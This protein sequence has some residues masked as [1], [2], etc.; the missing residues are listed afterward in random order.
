MIASHTRRFSAGAHLPFHVEIAL[1][2]YETPKHSV[3]RKIWEGGPHEEL[4]KD[5]EYHAPRPRL[6]QDVSSQ[7]T[8]ELSMLSTLSIHFNLPISIDLQV[9]ALGLR[10]EDG[11]ADLIATHLAFKC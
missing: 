5:M 8:T 9:A 3:R 4:K 2:R 10:P 6:T 1:A 7:S 11:L